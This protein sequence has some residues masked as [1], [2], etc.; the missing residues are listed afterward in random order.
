[1][2]SKVCGTGLK[3][4]F[5]STSSDGGMEP[6]SEAWLDRLDFKA[7]AAARARPGQ[8]HF[9]EHRAVRFRM[10]GRTSMRPKQVGPPPDTRRVPHG[11]ACPASTSSGAARTLARRA[12]GG[13][14]IVGMVRASACE[15]RPGLS[16]CFAVWAR[17][18]LGWAPSMPSGPS[19]R[20]CREFVR[21]VAA[22]WGGPG[23]SKCMRSGAHACA[24]AYLEIPPRRASAQPLVVNLPSVQP[25]T[26]CMGPEPAWPSALS[27][28]AFPRPRRRSGI[29]TRW[30]DRTCHV[31]SF[32]CCVGQQSF[33]NE[34][35]GKS[36]D[37]GRPPRG[38]CPSLSN[39][40]EFDRICAKHLSRPDFGRLGHFGPM[41]TEFGP[42]STRFTQ[43]WSR[44]GQSWAEVDNRRAVVSQNRPV[45]A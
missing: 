35:R 38:L 31:A 41:S 43:L 29:V 39:S 20:A 5:V 12:Q 44:V 40:P 2:L 26:L 33:R 22:G 27:R 8:P 24:G 17:R 1:M 9:Q 23:G 7:H 15:P 6:M 18:R 16:M 14:W 45:W 32:V 13:S 37:A 3:Q 11:P 42:V 34:G 36:G 30:A 10:D 28:G 4:M 21:A 25:A 19:A